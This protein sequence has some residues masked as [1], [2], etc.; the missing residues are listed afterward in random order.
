MEDLRWII[1]ELIDCGAVLFDVETNPDIKRNFLRAWSTRELLTDEI[2]DRLLL[3]WRD[4]L[5][6]LS[7]LLDDGRIDFSGVEGLCVKQSDRGFD[8]GDLSWSE[9]RGHVHGNYRWG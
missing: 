6:V 5:S 7:E 4:T 8:A 2:R 1:E 9:E 3:N